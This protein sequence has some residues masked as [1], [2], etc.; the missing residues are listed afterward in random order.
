MSK[1]MDPIN[2][3]QGN[4][5]IFEKRDKKQLKENLALLKVILETKRTQSA[6]SMSLSAN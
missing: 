2:S 3:L 1:P 6:G 5:N 4:S